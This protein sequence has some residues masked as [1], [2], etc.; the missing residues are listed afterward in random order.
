LVAWSRHSD[1][2]LLRLAAPLPASYQGLPRLTSNLGPSGRRRSGGSRVRALPR[3]SLPQWVARRRVGR[4]AASH[5]GPAGRRH[6]SAAQCVRGVHGRSV[7][8]NGTVLL[9]HPSGDLKKVSFDADPP[10]TAYFGEPCRT[11][12][13]LEA[14]PVPDGGGGAGAGDND[15]DDDD[16]EEEEC[17]G[18]ADWEVEQY[19]EGS[20]EGGSSGAPL[21]DLQGRVVGQV[22]VVP[23]PLRP[24]PV[25]S[26]LRDHSVLPLSI[27]LPSGDRCTA[28]SRRAHTRAPT[29]SAS[30][31]ACYTPL[32]CYSCF[33]LG[34]P[35]SPR[36]TSWPGK[37]SAS[38][39]NTI[40][41]SPAVPISLAQLQPYLDPHGVGAPAG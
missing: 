4:P 7:P 16:E 24:R 36:C 5:P 6:S 17:Y 13:H 30:S 39:N 37:L 27:T 35:A 31:S 10:T 38:Y 19:E 3:C 40:P 2:A 1:F 15:D 20:S 32:P 41:T 33:G 18:H 21:L 9:H 14:S 12:Q 23:S 34:T 22:R 25:T 28:A 29:S 11:G 8:P 26:P